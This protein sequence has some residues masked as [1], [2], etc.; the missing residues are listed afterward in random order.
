MAS[1]STPPSRL[2]KGKE[3]A[4]KNADEEPL[5][6]DTKFAVELLRSSFRKLEVV[7]EAFDIKAHHDVYKD[8]CVKGLAFK[9]HRFAEKLEN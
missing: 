7:G 8:P 5:F 6:N 1:R 3:P 2:E 4:A 9:I